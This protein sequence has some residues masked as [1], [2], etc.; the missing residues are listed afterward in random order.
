MDAHYLAAP[1]RNIAFVELAIASGLALLGGDQR[2]P[3]IASTVG[4]GQLIVDAIDRGARTV[5]LFLGGS[6]TVDAGIGIAHAL[7]FR[8]L[9]SSE[10]ELEP[11]GQSLRQIASIDSSNAHAELNNVTFKIICDVTNPLHGPQGAAVVYGPQKGAS[12]SDVQC[13]DAGLKHFGSLLADAEPGIKDIP[14]TGAAGGIAAS[15]LVLTKAEIVSGIEFFIDV[16][17]LEEKIVAAD[18]IVTGEG[19]IDAQSKAGKVPSGVLQLAN[20]HGKPVVAV[21]GDAAGEAIGDFGF[22]AVHTVRGKATSL[23]DSIENTDEYL[24]LIGKEIAESIG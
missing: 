12:P 24:F 21:C 15:L 2:N 9:D 18:L 6:S 7:G 3:R 5:Y 22:S 14:G 20:R 4:T 11:V 16:T 23:A 13:L 17:R 1:Q 10:N 19:K 8:F